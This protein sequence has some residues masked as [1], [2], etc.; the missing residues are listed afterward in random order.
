[1]PLWAGPSIVERRDLERA[2]GG[3]FLGKVLS[4]KPTARSQ[5]HSWETITAAQAL[6]ATGWSA[7]SSSGRNCSM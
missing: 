6:G 5:T 7:S 2:T 3:E 1:M 4:A